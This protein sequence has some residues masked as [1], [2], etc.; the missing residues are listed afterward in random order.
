MKKQGPYAAVTVRNAPFVERTCQLKSDHP[1][2]GYRR[3]GAQMVYGNGLKISKHRVERLM[4]TMGC[5]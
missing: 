2:W 5:R 1:F 4:R 3:V